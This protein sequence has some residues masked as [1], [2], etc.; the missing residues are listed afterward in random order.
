M[1]KFIHLAFLLVII[2][3]ISL[4]HSFAQKNAT[5]NDGKKVILYDNGTWKY[6][7]NQTNNDYKSIFNLTI[8]NEITLSICNGLIIN[9]GNNLGGSIEYI[10]NGYQNAG[11]IKKIGNMTIEYIDNGNQNAGKVKKI[12]NLTIE[13]ISGGYQNAGKVKKIGNLAIEYIDNGYQNAGKLKRIGNVTVEYISGGY[14]NAGKIK[15][16]NGSNP[17]IVMSVN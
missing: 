9:F 3:F 7:D 16:V 6:V 12:G 2:N 11:K 10:D 13:Y 14:Q 17:N 8:K 5:T 15:K 4:H 1:I